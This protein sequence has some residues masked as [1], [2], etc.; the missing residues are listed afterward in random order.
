MTAGAS[1]SSDPPSGDLIPPPT[2]MQGSGRTNS[3]NFLRIVLAV[4]VI[5]SHAVELGYFGTWEQV[6]RTTLGTVAVYGFFGISGYLIAGSALRNGPFRYLWQRFL[7]IFPAFWVCLIVTAFGIGLIGWL[8]TPGHHDHL[9]SYFDARTSP[10]GY[11]WRNF[12]LKIHQ[13]SIAGTP[14]GST[15]PLEWN[16]SIWTLFYEFLCYLILMGLA[17][18]GLLRRRFAVLMITLALM[19]AMTVITF[20]GS[21]NGSFNLIHHFILMNLIRFGTIFLTGALLYLYR[22]RVPDSGWIALGCSAIFIAEL[23]LP[24]NNQ[25]P[26]FALTASGLMSPLIAYPMIW[27][28]YHLPLQRVGAKNDYSYGLYV[29]AY[30]VQ[31]LLAIWGVIRWGFFAYFGLALAITFPLAIASWWAIEKHALK[32]KRFELSSIVGRHAPMTAPLPAVIRVDASA[33]DPVVDDP[34][35]GSPL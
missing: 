33:D 32:L 3:L 5:L 14:T 19:V 30:P 27:L 23:W 21:L 6:N 18:V 17:A 25:Y 1:S 34:A 20:D 22:D 35:S 29:Y 28:G 9:S 24:T 11:I 4:A 10:F 26:A 31:Q 2:G 8:S 13:T 15:Q 16:G 7:R 12:L